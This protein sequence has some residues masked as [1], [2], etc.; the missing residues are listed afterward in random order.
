MRKYVSAIAVIASLYAGLGQLNATHEFFGASTSTN[1]AIANAFREQT[2]GVQVAGK[3]VVTKVLSDDTDGSRHQRFI[4]R[5]DSGQTLLVAHNIDIASRLP[6]LES[7][8]AVEFKGV[9]EWNSK[10]GVIHWTHRDPRGEH[11][12]GWLKYNGET[13]Q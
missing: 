1:E 12:G 8:D 10:G 13:Y 5:V 4:L 3:G 2:S 7:G 6:S 9:Y 11:Q